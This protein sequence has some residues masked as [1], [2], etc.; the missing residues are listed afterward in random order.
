MECVE[1]GIEID[2]FT[3]NALGSDVTDAVDWAL[4]IMASV[5]EI[6]RNEL[7]DLVTLEAR[8]IHVWTSPDPYASV[9][10][11]GGGLLGAFNSEWF[12]VGQVV[13]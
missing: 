6:Y 2:Q 10:N 9:V 8:F 3:Y 1:V 13:C 4:A 7:N 12:F 5:D 11:D